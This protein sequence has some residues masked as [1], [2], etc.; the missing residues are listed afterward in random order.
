MKIKSIGIVGYGQ[1]GSFIHTLI[2]KFLPT[3]DVY[4]FDPNSPT[5]ADLPLVAKSDV[6]CLCVPI[7]EYK[8]TIRHLAPLLG[9]A[10]VVLDVATVKKVTSQWCREYLAEGRYVCTHPM[11]GP[12]SYRKK[13]E[14]ING[15]R[16][17]VTDK[18]ISEREW[19][20]VESWLTSLGLISIEMTSDEHDKYLAETLFLTHYVAQVITEASFVRT[21]ID[22]VSFG[23]LMDA[24]ESVRDD[25]SLFADVYRFNPYC[26]RVLESFKNAEQNVRSVLEKS[27]I[28]GE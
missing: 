28:D 7:S 6:V 22:T 4:I 3:I 19:N 2:Q 25:R 23:F 21:Q 20:A 26:T 27:K 10:S 17:V 5:S 12:A 24:V 14:D 16:L 8:E 1:F 11:F 15:L 9:N 13:G 18:N